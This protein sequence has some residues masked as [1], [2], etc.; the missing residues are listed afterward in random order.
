MKDN[1]TYNDL[2]N[3]AFNDEKVL[4]ADLRT[5]KRYLLACTELREVDILNPKVI[6]GIP[7]R[8][9]FIREMIS[10]ELR[11]RELR[12]TT[13]SIV[14]GALFALGALI[15]CIKQE[16]RDEARTTPTVA[17]SQSAPP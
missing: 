11:A 5:L 8:K 6:E 9:E 16:F 17:P 1:A 3:A 15:L 12:L 13:L 14:S 2:L 7:K 10:L 4:S